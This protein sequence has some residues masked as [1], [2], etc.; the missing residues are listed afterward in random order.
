MGP[1]EETLQDLWQIRSTGRHKQPHEN[2][3]MQA[4]QAASES[5][6]QKDGARSPRSCSKE[7]E[8]S[9]TEIA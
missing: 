8:P 4:G 7:K 2:Q 3:E 1:I 6:V 9:A 5:R